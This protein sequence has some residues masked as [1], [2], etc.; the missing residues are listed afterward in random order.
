MAVQAHLP[1]PAVPL[2]EIVASPPAASP[3]EEKPSPLIASEVL[4]PDS[5]LASSSSVAA[6]HPPSSEPNERTLIE[7]NAREREER[8]FM[9]R[10]H[11]SSD[12]NPF[13]PKTP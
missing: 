10:E 9:P 11:C 13:D 2:P 3:L 1:G 4:P 12:A 8:V 7:T 6:A 5:R